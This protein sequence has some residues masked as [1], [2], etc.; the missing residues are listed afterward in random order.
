MYTR[1]IFLSLSLSD[2]FDHVLREGVD[3]LTVKVR[4]LIV[5]YLDSLALFLQY[6]SYVLLLGGGTH[7]SILTPGCPVQ[8]P[9]NLVVAKL[10]K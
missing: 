5:P 8:L 1:A 3:V 6:D 10:E 4:D 7:V 2:T 9:S